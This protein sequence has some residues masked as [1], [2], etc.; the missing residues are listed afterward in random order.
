VDRKVGDVEADVVVA[1]SSQF[2]SAMRRNAGAIGCLVT[3]WRTRVPS[4]GWRPAGN[5]SERSRKDCPMPAG[6]LPSLMRAWLSGP[7]P[8]IGR[9]GDT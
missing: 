5:P 7:L 8:R 9:F 3:G 6:A 2:G 4:A 1:R